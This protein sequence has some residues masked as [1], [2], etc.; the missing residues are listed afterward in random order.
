MYPPP[1]GQWNYGQP[2]QPGYPPGYAPGP[3]GYPMA[4]PPQGTNGFAIAS[5][6]LGLLGCCLLAVPFGFIALSQIKQRNQG[7]RGLAIAGLVIT[8]V[9]AVLAVGLLAIGVATDS[10]KSASPDNSTR[11]SDPNGPTSVSISDLKTGDCVQTVKEG[12]HVKRVTITPCDSAHDAEVI[13]TVQ[14]PG[15]WPGSEDAA[16]KKASDTCAVQLDQ[17]MSGSSM[18]DQ[19]ENFILY[20]ANAAQWNLSNG[21]ASC[22]VHY[23]DGRKLTGKVPR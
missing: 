2:G 17:L 1:A 15:S 12:D 19:L 5:F 6:V 4:P 16:F 23:A 14:L 11:T 13:T 18:Y 21:R 8:A 10:H 9:Y 3:P 22:M 7:G 20:P